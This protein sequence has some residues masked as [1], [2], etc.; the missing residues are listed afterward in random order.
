MRK[1][2]IVIFCIFCALSIGAGTRVDTSNMQLMHTT[3]YYRGHHTANGSKVHIGGCSCNPHLG[4]VAIIYTVDGQ[5]LGMYECNDTGGTQGLQ[6]GTVI[7][8]YRK[9]LTQCETWMKITG[10]KVYVL[11]IEGKG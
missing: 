5:Y 7:D 8:V 4:D 1:V 9:N 11:W 2:L 3:A 10:G 6:N